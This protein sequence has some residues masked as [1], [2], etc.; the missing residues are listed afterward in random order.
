MVSMFIPPPPTQDCSFCMTDND[1]RVC[2]VG[3]TVPMQQSASGLRLCYLQYCLLG[4]ALFGGCSG[5]QLVDEYGE[6]RGDVGKQSVNGTAVLAD[7]FTQAGCR[8]RRWSRMSPRLEHADIIVWIPDSFGPPSVEH[9]RFV[10]RWL[11]GDQGRTLIYVGRDYDARLTYWEKM[12]KKTASY[13]ESDRIR[14]ESKR[15]MAQRDH[16]RLR[17]AFDGDPY[18]GW[19]IAQR[20]ATRETAKKLAG[21]W[22]TDLQTG[23]VDLELWT[24]LNLPRVDQLPPGM[25]DTMIPHSEVLMTV[26]D[27]VLIRRVWY[28]H[29]DDSEVML[30]SNG[31]FL[32]NLPLVNHDHRKLATRL[33]RHAVQR[34]LTP[35][36]KNVVFL[37]SSG[38]GPK[39][40]EVEPRMLEGSGLNAFTSWPLGVILIHLLGWGIICCVWR[41]P[42]FGRPHE[43]KRERT[44][45]FGKHVTALGQQLQRTGNIQYAQE[46]LEQYQRINRS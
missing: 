40:Y 39:V 45:D 32:L 12:L 7:L 11:Q 29:W 27:D 24:R 17:N 34:C 46:K 31:S 36:N 19:F 6:V 22:S 1:Y 18:G 21:P 2:W 33:V 15:R 41:F 4:V 37:V 23:E 35:E 10:D 8:V 28:D 43:R 25:D 42:I 16:E 9:R 26:N 38:D 13:S 5:E 30:I 14:Y 20:N 3:K 44:A